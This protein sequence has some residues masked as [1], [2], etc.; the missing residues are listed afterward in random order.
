[1]TSELGH[2]RRIVSTFPH[3]GL[4]ALGEAS[5]GVVGEEDTSSTHPRSFWLDY[6]LNSHETE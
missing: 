1:M 4:F 2:I 3:L 5:H 6:E